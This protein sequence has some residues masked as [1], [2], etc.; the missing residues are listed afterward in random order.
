MPEQRARLVDAPFGDQPPDA[1]AADDEVLV[2]DRVDLLG[3]EAVARAEACAAP[4]RCRRDRGRTGS[5][6]RPRPRRRAAS[7]PARS[8]T[9]VSGSHCDSSCVK[10][11]TATPCMP[12]RPSA[13]SFC[14]VVIS[15]GGALS[16]RSTRGGCGI[17]GHRGRRA[18]ALAGAAPHAVD[19]LHVAAVQPVEV[20]ERE[21]RLV[22]ARRRVVGKMGDGQAAQRSAAAVAC[23]RRLQLEL[24]PPAHHRPAPC[25]GQPGARSPH[26]PGRGTCA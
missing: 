22:P 3:A 6:R 11:T 15:S 10:R 19:D 13:S 9:N 25:P 12:A 21:H 18:A 16:G 5:W 8:R 17:E 2:A 20:A 23:T 24:P 4:R 1:R 14:A 26:A 7:R